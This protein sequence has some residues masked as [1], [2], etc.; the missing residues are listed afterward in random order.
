MVQPQTENTAL[1]K[2]LKDVEFWRKGVE[3]HEQTIRDR[4]AEI[5]TLK[6]ELAKQNGVDAKVAAL[7]SDVRDATEDQVKARALLAKL[8]DHVAGRNANMEKS[9]TFCAICENPASCPIREVTEMI[10]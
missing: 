7:Q 4:D 1:T 10:G 2:A 9:K 8:A 5:K 6:A 3:E